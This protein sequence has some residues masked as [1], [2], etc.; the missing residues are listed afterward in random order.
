[1]ACAMRHAIEMEHTSAAEAAFFRVFFGTAE[2]VPFQNQT[3][4]ISFGFSL[5]D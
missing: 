3:D 4:P 2:A 1:M 5:L